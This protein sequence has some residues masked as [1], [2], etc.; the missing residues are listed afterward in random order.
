[1]SSILNLILFISRLYNIL[2]EFS[3]ELC[4]SRENGPSNSVL[5]PLE[6]V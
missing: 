1:M 2:L 4:F 6:Y 3:V 5:C